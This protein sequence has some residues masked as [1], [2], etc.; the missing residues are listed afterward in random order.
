[1]LVRVLG[2]IEL[3]IDGS[4]VPIGSRMGRLLL[5]ALTLAAN[6]MVSSDQL[7][8]ILWRDNPP[9]SRDVTLHSHLSRLRRLLGPGRITG[10]DHSYQLTIAVDE[11]DAL[12][13][14][15]LVE[16]ALAARDR[17]RVCRQRCR[18]A[19]GLWRGSAFGEFGD[20]DPFRLEAIRLSELRLV[21]METRL[22]SEL[23]LGEEEVVAG[24]LEAMV[25][26]YPYRERL[27]NL[28]IAALALS[29]RRVEALRSCNR[30]R[31]IL[32]EVGLEPT[33]AI[34][35]LEAAIFAEAPQIR[36]RLRTLI[37]PEPEAYDAD[38][39]WEL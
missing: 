16:Q 21:V 14:E 7:S 39:E 27:W 23:A 28:Y 19:L 13:F 32:A 15:T 24:A 4:P 29:G 10:G 25:E 38:V 1:M 12:R 36:T 17:P 30:L 9:P 26:E 3:E 2:P 11:L 33:S 34:R 37:R 18:Q 8:M 6:H 22:E 20:L 31:G 35:E 5:A